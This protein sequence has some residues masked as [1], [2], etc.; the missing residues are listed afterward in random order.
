MF[1]MCFISK[2]LDEMLGNCSEREQP[3]CCGMIHQEFLTR[4]TVVVVLLLEKLLPN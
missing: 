1:P 4:K 3:F 2:E